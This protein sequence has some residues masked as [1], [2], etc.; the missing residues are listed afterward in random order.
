M[1]FEFLNPLMLIGLAGVT[2]PVIAHLLSRK[3][4]DVVDWGAMQFLELGR[5]ARR[6]I[7]LE[8]LLLLLL[9]M[10]M[11]ALLAIALARPWLAASFL[12]WF[13]PNE[14][15]DVVI[16]VDGSYSMGWQGGDETPHAAAIQWA[17]QFL[18]TLHSA[19]SV[20]LIDSRDTVHAVLEKP[21]R[22]FGAVRGKLDEMPQPSGTSDLLAAA[23]RS[24]QILGKSENLQRDIVIITDDQALGWSPDDEALWTR[25]DE[26]KQQPAVDPKVWVL[27]VESK[28]NQPRVNFAVHRLEA[29]RELSVV[30]FPV[31][32]KTKISYSGSRE[33]T[34]RRVYLEVNGQRLAEKTISI[35]L[36]PGGEA[37]VEFEH[38]FQSEGS[39]VLS[40]VLDDDQLPGDNQSHVAVQVVKALPVLLVDGHPSQDAARS[41]LFFACA[42]ISG[43]LNPDPWIDARTKIWDEFRLEDLADANVALFA[44]VPRFSPELAKGL[45]NY[46]EQG[47]GVGFFLAEGVDKDSYNEALYRGG[48]GLL[49]CEIVERIIADESS[50]VDDTS[51]ELP[52]MLR[53][54]A[55]NDGGFTDARFS[56]W[57]KLKPAK[58][59][60]LTNV[61]SGSVS[62]STVARLNTKDALLLSRRYGRGNVVVFGSSIDADWS[63]L[64][65]KQDYV[66]FL[67]E[68][69]F[70]MASGIGSRN[71][72]V[73]S[74]LVLNIDE[75]SEIDDFSAVSPAEEELEIEASENTG[76][77]GIQISNTRLPGIYTVTR[78]DVEDDAAVKQYFVVNDNRA[79]SDLS[80]LSDDQLDFLQQDDRMTF[81]SKPGDIE[82]KASDDEE[83]PKSEIWH[84]LLLAFLVILVGEVWLTRRMVRGGAAAVDEV[85]DSK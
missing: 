29:S 63:T 49:P 51:L 2:L 41:E 77:P 50:T 71:V 75:D 11:I 65:S 27:N 24:V 18:E 14:K 67:H 64:P 1:G 44:D 4:Y 52:W 20:A 5:E 32:L 53:F 80:A 37:S 36:D 25:F 66:P 78:N 40:V 81:V 48:Q 16:V 45:A 6:R 82:G 83:A 79:E 58:G 46:I 39:Y 68:M 61:A 84:L 3:K 43:R 31:R 59:Q 15:R 17:H 73:G 21:V 23:S 10:G 12:A 42:A 55:E 19:D 70:Q 54:K 33:A 62:V 69:I 76:R 60:P 28:S 9:R 7:R 26:L 30:N 34:N 8:E 35:Q 22:N 85:R 74:P 57:W 47:G 13:L 56:N 72:D 38:R